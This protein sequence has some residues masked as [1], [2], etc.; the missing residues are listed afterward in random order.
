MTAAVHYFGI[1]HHGP[2]SARA[3]VAALD[4]LAPSHVLIEGPAD[5]SD[6]LP[7]LADP[8]MVPPVALLAYAEDAPESASFWP[9]A[10]YSPEY[11]AV[12]WAVRNR[13]E[14]ALIDLPVS[15]RVPPKDEDEV[16][17]A[18]DA[19]EAGIEAAP[20]NPL[21]HDPIGALAAVAGYDDG[22]SWWRDVIEENPE[23]G[24]VFAAVA[25][26]MHAVRAETAPPEPFEAARE[27]H[28]RLEIARIRKDA[29][30]PVAVVCG[31]WH[32]PAL[33]EKH[34]L[35]DDR[36]LLKGAPKRKIAATWAPWTSPRLATGSGYGAG[37]TAPE[38]CG[39]LWTAPPDTVA[40]RWLGRIIELLREDGHIVSTASLIEAQRLGHT[41]AAL[42]DRPAPGFEELRDA[43]VACL[44][45]GQWTQWH[46]I[47]A[48]LLI[49]DTVGE[50]PETVP[51]APLLEDLARQ[52]KKARLKPE[53]LDKDISLDLRTDSGLFRST[54]LHRLT[55]LGVR[56]GEQTD[57][58]RSRGTFRERW[59]LRWEPEYAVGL[60]ENIV[61]GPTI[62]QAARGKTIA[63]LHDTRALNALAQLTRDAMTAQLPDA[64]TVGIAR[65]S[66]RA[67]VTDNCGELL[68]TLPPLADL[69]RYGE[70]R[71][72]DTASMEDLLRRIAVQGALA[73]PY[74]VRSLDEAAARMMTDA[75]RQA[76][77]A[78][79]LAEL[80]VDDLTVWEDALEALLTD[81]QAS[82]LVAGAAAQLLFAADRLE[83]EEASDLLGRMLSPGVEVADA[84]A[85][86]EGFF[87]GSCE[88][89]LYDADLRGALD[90]WLISLDD[91]T[92]TAYLPLFRRVFSALDK[93][94]RGRLL[95]ELFERRRA[96]ASGFVLT[97]TADAD[98]A[99]HLGIVAGI[100]D[101]EAR[102]G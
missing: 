67:G 76:D 90:T 3:L 7:L 68:T 91:D 48:R 58:G 84:A 39:H 75:V 72:T 28:M 35:K 12:L 87:E 100:L 30:G 37:V 71:A 21:L 19:P 62:E 70:A 95:D 17:E 42:R 16:I 8:G 6:L 101:G 40:I 53:A 96:Q 92:F 1:R 83:P 2:G 18:E 80:G 98:W 66:D 97:E 45:H 69:V 32:V 44:C 41:L 93:T 79:R 55:I 13:A 54:L 38:W 88:R 102:H 77:G 14:M 33:Q 24:P 4:A 25:D 36:A 59:R 94:Q 60:V 15:W 56:W 78:I 26:A 65:L 10:D 5:C 52:Q 47:A 34:A 86:F 81:A 49:G 27:A 73:L 99:R 23:P 85:F 20:E 89:L 43:T 51:R 29:T 11:Q 82:R 64:V 46:S 74:A 31:A 9:F 50:I 63:A 61:H 57:P 22:E